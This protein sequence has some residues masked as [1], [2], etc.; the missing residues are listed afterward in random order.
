MSR[1]TQAVVE[2]LNDLATPR[3][4]LGDQLNELDGRRSRWRDRLCADLLFD[5]DDEQEFEFADGSL[6]PSLRD[7]LDDAI[8]EFIDGTDLDLAIVPTIARLFR[9]ETG[10][11]REVDVSGALA[12][13]RPEIDQDLTE[14][15]DAITKEGKRLNAAFGPVRDRLSDWLDE[16]TRGAGATAIEWGRIQKAW[17]TSL[18]L[19]MRVAG[20]L[21]DISSA[22]IARY[23]TG[24]RTPS[25]RSLASLVHRIN[26]AG[27]TAGLDLARALRSTSVLL[28]SDLFTHLELDPGPTL[29]AAIE[30]RLPTLTTE[31]LRFIDT[32]ISDP[33]ALEQFVAW[34]AA[35]PTGLLR[36]VASI[37]GMAP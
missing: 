10:G 20:E 5:G 3:R 19:P 8:A 18:T 9:H 37:E 11:I 12:E 29:I 36:A 21:L 34:T 22:A 32:L 24:T 16:V 1:T 17:R 35:A 28:G 27:P 6:A 2:A 33:L 25:L 14:V 15:A 30:D 31:H 7:G 4:A 26:D 13:Y 23:E